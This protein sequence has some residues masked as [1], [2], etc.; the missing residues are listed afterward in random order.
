MSTISAVIPCWG[1]G[2]SA[3]VRARQRPQDGELR[4]GR[5]H[6]AARDL[7]APVDRRRPRGER[8]QVAPGVGLAEELAPD[9]LGREDGGQVAQTLVLGAVRQQRRAHQV[10]AHPVH[11]LGGLGPGVLALV[12]RDLHRRGAAPAVGTGPVHADPAVGGEGRLPLPA[13]RHL[14]GQVDEGGRAAQVLAEPL[15]E[16]GGELLVLFFS[17]RSTPAPSTTLTSASRYRRP[18]ALAALTPDS[19][20]IRVQGIAGSAHLFDLPLRAEFTPVRGRHIRPVLEPSAVENRAIPQMAMGSSGFSTRCH[21]PIPSG[22]R[23]P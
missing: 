19:A 2:A 1:R 16:G 18:G 4:V 23:T 12:Q 17:A 20:E 8:R 21:V 7:E 22:G 10:D 14:V 6:L 13:P 5:P 3:S 9:L 11:R 15:P